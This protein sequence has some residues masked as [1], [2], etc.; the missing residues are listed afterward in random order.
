MESKLEKHLKAGGELAQT[1]LTALPI[2]GEAKLIELLEE[3]ERQGKRLEITYPIDP[4]VG[5]SE[6]DGIAIV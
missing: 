3:A 5:P 2:V 6:P 4:R 1:L